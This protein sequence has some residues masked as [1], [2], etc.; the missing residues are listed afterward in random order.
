M[1]KKISLAAEKTGKKFANEY[2]SYVLL[3]NN[4]EVRIEM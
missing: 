1:C 4:K 3:E 2:G